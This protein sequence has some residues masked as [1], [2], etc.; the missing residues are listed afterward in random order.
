MTFV[1]PDEVCSGA[2]V[3]Y[4]SLCLLLPSPLEYK[5]LGG[6]SCVFYFSKWPCDCVTWDYGCC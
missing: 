2:S 6:K 1:V 3:L 4:V 5:F